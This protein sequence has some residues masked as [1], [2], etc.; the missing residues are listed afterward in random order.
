MSEI[1]QVQ[2]ADE[3][4]IS[5]EDIT[6]SPLVAAIFTQMAADSEFTTN[7]LLGAYRS[8]IADLRATLTAV[9]A[10]IT[11]LLDGDYMP[12]SAALERALWPS[13]AVVD[14][15]REESS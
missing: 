8:E 2:V 13:S 15:H 1:Q 5:G 7:T 3:I 12:T 6:M 10:G 14:F 11:C 4:D 9:R